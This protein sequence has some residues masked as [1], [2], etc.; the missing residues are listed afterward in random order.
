MKNTNSQPVTAADLR[1][2]AEQRLKRQRPTGAAPLTAAETAR[3]LHELQV[4]QIELEMQNEELHRT[5]VELELSRARYFDLYDLA[6]VGYCTVSETGLILDANLTLATW[7]GVKRGALVTQLFSRFTLKED[8]DNFHDLRQQ[9]LATRRPQTCELRM[10]PPDS[11]PFWAQLAASVVPV[12]G[13]PPV[14]RVVLSD[15]TA[16]KQTEA[17]LRL[18]EEKFAKAFRSSPDGFILSSV[19]EGRIVE[20]NDTVTRISGYTPEELLGRTTVELGLWVDP[21]VRERYA[22]TVRREGRVTNFEGVF[23]AKS[24]ELHTCLISTEIIPLQNGPHFLSV[25]RDITGQKQAEE[26]ARRWEQVFET[27]GFALAHSSAAD[28]TFLEVN[29]VCAHERGYTPEE[30]VGQPILLIYPPEALPAMRERLQNIDRVGHLVFE[31]VHLRKDGSTFP[32]L[33]DVTTIRDAKGR[34]V[35]RVAYALDITERKQAEAELQKR[36]EELVRFAD[37]MVGREMRV[38]GLKEEINA[39]CRKQGEPP[40]YGPDAADAAPTPPS[41]LS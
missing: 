27:S 17:E 36:H 25:L 16:R 6:P 35:S 11:P 37:A 8:H 41:T 26:Q 10:M 14:L 40:R 4:H 18:S 31:S 32:V 15:L 2:Q 28:N 9:L 29:A 22:D 1:R 23:R 39:L 3:L 30:L 24:G 34:P 12:A 19:P 21:E 20:V 7:L 33:M 38:I 13:G 5:Q